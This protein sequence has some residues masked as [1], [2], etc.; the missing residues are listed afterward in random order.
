MGG[1][2]ENGNYDMKIAFVDFNASQSQ[3]PAHIVAFGASWSAQF[4]VFELSVSFKPSFQPLGR[5]DLGDCW[6]LGLFDLV[7]Q[8]FD[9]GRCAGRCGHGRGWGSSTGCSSSSVGIVVGVDCCTISTRPTRCNLRMRRG[10]FLASRC[11]HRV[12]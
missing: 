7:V 4:N 1:W 11:D 3:T 10:R 8:R 6:E 2:G 9:D 12:S 5:P